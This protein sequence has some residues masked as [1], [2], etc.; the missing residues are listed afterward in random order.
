M[1]ASLQTV[2]TGGSQISG[3]SGSP[4]GLSTSTTIRF[5]DTADAQA[6][7]Q[8]CGG[9]CSDWPS[10]DMVFGTPVCPPAGLCQRVTFIGV[11]PGGLPGLVIES[12][13]YDGSTIPYSGPDETDPPFAFLDDAGSAADWT[14][15]ITPPDLN[16]FTGFVWPSRSV[17]SDP[18]FDQDTDPVPPLEM[19]L[20]ALENDRSWWTDGAD[21]PE[22]RDISGLLVPM[23]LVIRMPVG[24]PDRVIFDYTDRDSIEI[25]GSG[26]TL[27][28]T[29]TPIFQ[30]TP[31]DITDALAG[32]TD[33]GAGT[34]D[35]REGEWDID[36]VIYTPDGRAIYALDCYS[37][38]TQTV[39]S[40]AT[41]LS[42]VFDTARVHAAR[43]DVRL[44]LLPFWVDTLADGNK[45]AGPGQVRDETTLVG[46]DNY[47]V[48]SAFDNDPLILTWNGTTVTAG[49]RQIATLGI[50]PSALAARESTLPQVDNS[51]NPVLD[52]TGAEV[53][54]PVLELLIA[55]VGADVVSVYSR[56]VR[57]DQTSETLLATIPL[58]FDVFDGETISATQGLCFSSDATKLAART[59]VGE[60]DE[61][62]PN[63]PFYPGRA[64]FCTW[65]SASGFDARPALPESTFLEEG[66]RTQSTAAALLSAHW[67]GNT[68]IETV[69]KTEG[70]YT[71]TISTEDLPRI[72]VGC[73]DYS[74]AGGWVERET[75]TSSY[76][77][78]C[79]YS[80]EHGGVEALRGRT[81]A[82]STNHILTGRPTTVYL[83]IY[84]P[85]NVP[86][87]DLMATECSHDGL[88][89]AVPPPETSG[90]L[91]KRAFQN[92][93]FVNPSGDVVILFETDEQTHTAGLSSSDH[94]GLVSN[95]NILTPGA[96]YPWETITHASTMTATAA[97]GA[98]VEL[99]GYYPWSYRDTVGLESPFD[100]RANRALKNILTQTVSTNA[101]GAKNSTDTLIHASAVSGPLGTARGTAVNSIS[102]VD[103]GGLT[104]S[105]VSAQAKYRPPAIDYD[106][107]PLESVPLARPTADEIRQLIERDIGNVMVAVDA[108]TN[109]AAHHAGWCDWW[110]TIDVSARGGIAARAAAEGY[111][112]SIVEIIVTA[113]SAASA[114]AVITAD[115]EW[116]D[117]AARGWTECG[118]HVMDSQAHGK[119]LIV[120]ELG[121]PT[122]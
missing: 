107:P 116:P 83:T 28:Y 14:I 17:E 22:M 42:P 24:T 119:W 91:W 99:A 115:P 11:V 76:V 113:P 46:G 41:G 75:V 88:Y 82:I 9:G 92:I 2:L 19:R 47:W 18:P 73:P 117:R 60:F 31:G 97:D 105:S 12:A 85:D 32:Y 111:E 96:Y 29:D 104:V 13:S 70:D 86:D 80:I 103:L 20:Q 35:P 106:D 48:G 54:E 50:T 26:E 100:Y 101:T 21:G 78:G 40:S 58:G 34:M 36:W 5:T 56:K 66:G 33:G 59:P 23:Q 69:I 43:V 114:V 67:D 93:A 37:G 62:N 87:W 79:E 109:M 84:P 102:L 25:T 110:G 7:A 16:A 68:L 61:D 65:A 121:A 81:S 57:G 90:T 89:A 44:P 8:P 118:I 39:A 38:E 49:G 77:G 98:T 63:L 30:L 4:Q 55:T 74:L 95:P 27:T 52:D 64:F 45:Q 1:T 94:G 51:G 53:T 10:G 71:Y 120:I 108:L 72:Y 122:A 15:N 112:N 3:G 6:A